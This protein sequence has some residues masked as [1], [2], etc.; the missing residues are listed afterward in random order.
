MKRSWLLRL[1]TPWS[2]LAIT[3]A[4]FGLVVLFV[5]LK[6]VVDE[7]FSFSSS[8]PQFRQS[9]KIERRFPSQ[10]QLILNIS[11]RD[12]SSPRYLARIERVSRDRS[13]KSMP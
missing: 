1:E 10:S 5:D 6:P 13:A 7:S 3:A 4:L 8:D 2:M 11:S 12:I 9:K